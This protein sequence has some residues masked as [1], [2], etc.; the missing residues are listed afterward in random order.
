MKINCSCFSIDII[1]LRATGAQQSS[2]E[3]IHE[4]TLDMLLAY[5]K[6][7]L[8]LFLPYMGSRRTMTVRK[9]QENSY[10]IPTKLIFVLRTRQKLA[11]FVLRTRQKPSIFV[12]STRQ[13]PSIFVLLTRQKLNVDAI[14]VIPVWKWLLQDGF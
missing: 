14:E 11:I 8:S 7:R 2:A 13:K 5:Y 10:I 12:L 9:S 3:P 4:I 6:L 1:A